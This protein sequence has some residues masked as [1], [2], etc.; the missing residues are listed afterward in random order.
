MDYDLISKVSL[1]ELKNFL[2][3][4]GQWEKKRA[5]DKSYSK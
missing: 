3:S 2:K 4:K 1:E 5:S